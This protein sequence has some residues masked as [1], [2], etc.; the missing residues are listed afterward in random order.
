MKK[1]LDLSV[2]TTCA[3]RLQMAYAKGYQAAALH[4][5]SWEGEEDD[6]I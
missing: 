2:N 5:F 1:V 6:T 3:R 4:L